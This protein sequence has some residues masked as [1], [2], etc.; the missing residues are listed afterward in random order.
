MSN[1]LYKEKPK[2]HRKTIQRLQGILLILL[3]VAFVILWTN[4]FFT[5][6]EFEQRLAGMVEGEDYFVEEVFITRKDRNSYY[7]TED[8]GVATT[9]YFFYYGN[10][11]DEKM[12]VSRTTYETYQ[13]GD[14]VP[15]YTTDH[16]SYAFTIEGILPKTEYKNNE[17]KKC[18]GV[19]A[20]L[21]VISLSAW[22]WIDRKLSF[23]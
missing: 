20:G 2:G 8:S 7:S 16:V 22:M 3:T 6:R 11:P 10:S 1:K 15:A 17:L 9:N 4:V 19:L 21:G 23:L 5:S 14:P 13:V 12:Q 18:A